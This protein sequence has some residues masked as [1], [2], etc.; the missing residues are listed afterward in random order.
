LYNNSFVDLLVVDPTD[1]FSIS[2]SNV[3]FDRPAGD[4]TDFTNLSLN[5]T[6]SAGDVY[7]INWSSSPLPAPANTT[8]FRN[9]FVNITTLSGSPSIDSMAWHWTNAESSGFAESSL[10]AWKTNDSVWLEQNAT[11]DT[12]ANTLSLTGLTDFSVFGIFGLLQPPGGDGDDEEEQPLEEEAPPPAC[13]S[14][15]QCAVNEQ[16]S[17]GFCQRIPCECGYYQDHQCVEYQCC[18][19]SDCAFNEECVGN[20]CR[21]KTVHECTVNEDCPETQFC[22][23]RPT[24]SGGSCKDVPIGACGEVKNHR[25][26]PYG[27]VCG[28]EPGC[29]SCPAGQQCVNHECVSQDLSCPSTGIVGDEKVCS[30]TEQGQPCANCPY[31][32]TDPTGKKFGGQTD[33]NGNLNLPLNL[34]GTYRVTLFKGGQPVKTVEIKVLQKAPPEEPEAPT[35]PSGPDLSLLGLLILAILVIFGIIYWRRKEAKK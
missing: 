31:E 7:G 3:I 8:A 9:K 2:L 1:D 24:E 25:F 26:V 27:Y 11:L 20:T 33:E 30:A 21:L 16:C 28:P 34:E 10:D 29:P 13:T 18:S 14:D 17:D 4:F 5:D 6:T 22:D 23:I 19:D 15:D 35:V 32:V 12:A